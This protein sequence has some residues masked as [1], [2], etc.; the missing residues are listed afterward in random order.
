MLS[1]Y[2][3]STQDVLSRYLEKAL[4]DPVTGFT[5]LLVIAT[6]LLALI[7]YLQIRQ[8]K[9]VQRAYV[10]VEPLGIHLM[11]EGDRL[12]GHVG[13]RNAGRL[14]AR[15]LSWFI[16]IKRSDKG[17]EEI[18][19]LDKGKGK[20][21]VTPGAMATR[22]SDKHIVLQDLI[23]ASGMDITKGRSRENPTYLYV[24]G[25]VYYK[26]GVRKIRWRFTKFCHRYNWIIREMG[27]ARYEIAKEYA[28][29]H[30]HG[31]DAN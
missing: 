8:N 3:Q 18:F 27:A 14:P 11:I 20:I 10:A 12:I 15:K 29:Y 6:V 9:I 19:P 1:H 17:N 24:W 22:G 13:I 28:R 23:S 21:T 30:E 4:D 25:V 2:V 16:N 26:D 5:A 7:A 31:N